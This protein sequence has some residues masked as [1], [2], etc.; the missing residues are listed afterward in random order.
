MAKMTPDDWIV[1]IDAALR[2]RDIFAMEDSW[3]SLEQMYLNDPQGDTAVGPN[4]I[5]SMGDSLMSSLMVPDPE[6]MLTPT[7]PAGVERAPVVEALDNWLVKKMKLKRHVDLALLNGYLFSKAILKIGYDS[8]FGWS[9]YYDIGPRNNFFGLTLTQFDKKGKR[10]EFKD[11]TPGLPWV[12]AVPPQDF[13]VPWGTI[14]LDDAHW[15][16]HRV[17]RLNEGI[18]ADPKYKNTTRFE[19]QIT[20]QA[21]MESY[22]RKGGSKKL[23]WSGGPSYREAVKAK[24]NELWEIHDKQ[25][26]KIFVVSRDY[27]K[28][29]RNEPDALQVAGLPFVAGGFVTHPRAFWSTPQAYYLG[30]IQHEQFDISMQMAKQRRISVLKFLARKGA[31]TEAQMTRLISGDVGAMEEAEIGASQSLKEVIATMPMGASLDLTMHAEHNR[32]DA[33][34][35]IGFSRN[36]LGEFDASSRRTARESTF[37]HEGAER[38]TSRRSGVVVDLYIDAIEKVN[39]IMFTFS[40]TPR[41]M[42]VGNEWVKFTGSEIAGDYL[43]DASLSTKRNLSRAERKIE[44]LMMLAQ[45]SQYPGVNIAGLHQYVLD[46][47][48]DPGFERIL[49]MPGGSQGAK[50]LPGGEAPT[51][52]ATKLQ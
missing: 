38:R 31:L 30:Q 48:N 52:P 23:K 9:P 39:K 46:A 29:L 19:P 32:R 2:Y 27:D 11:T 10:I 22:M 44:A 37:V 1:E 34:D 21:Y 8:E 28:Y 3:A 47:A 5:Y 41:Y 20:M 50:Q 49:Q 40:R 26:G 17:I 12:S 51:I 18:K 45:L 35:S 7:H 42:M 24:Y 6:F 4:L 16:A 43:Y 14:F 13:V 36:Q 33:R 25:T 15:C